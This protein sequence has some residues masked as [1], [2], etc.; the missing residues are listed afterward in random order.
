MDTRE[1]EKI[2]KIFTRVISSEEGIVFAYLYGSFLTENTFRDI[3]IFIYTGEG[4]DQFVYPVNVKE[5]LFDA[6]S[7]IGA[8]TFVID[9]FDVRIINNAPCYIVI[10]ILREGI[11]LADNNPDLR[12]DYI[13]RI[14][15]E[16][17][18][19]YFILDEA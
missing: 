15:N 18:V 2:V 4:I 5:K 16:Y 13:E 10:D 7:E 6:V 11:L 17:S 12:E 1:R 14:S 8:D 3:D 19:N 9:D